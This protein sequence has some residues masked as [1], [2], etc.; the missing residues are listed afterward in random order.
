MQ[1]IKNLSSVI[2][3]IITVDLPS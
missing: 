1:E 3:G 2:G